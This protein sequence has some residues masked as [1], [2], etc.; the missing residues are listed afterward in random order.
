MEIWKL[1]PRLTER[2]WQDHAEAG[3]LGG[4]HDPDHAMRVSQV[5]FDLWP[6]VLAAAAG[7]CHNADR[8]LQHEMGVA[9]RN[10]LIGQIIGLGLGEEEREVLIDAVSKHVFVGR[11]DVP[12]ERVRELVMRE[13]SVEDCFSDRGIE[14]VVNAVLGHDGKNEEGD[15]IVLKALMD[16]DRLVNGEPDLV[17]R[18]GQFLSD[19][20]AV[21]PIY[22]DKDPSASYRDPRS[23]LRD[24]ME[25]IVW[26]T[27]G[28]N[29]P[30]YV[31][32]PKARAMAA[33]RKPFFDN[34]LAE[35]VRRREESG[36]HPYPPELIELR[37]RFMG[38]RVD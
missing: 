4:H 1:L 13:L 2:I 26:F 18:S 12:K 10:A 15:D 24:V 33:E 29:N 27:P 37:D 22:L 17:M 28:E 20:P 38:A 3:M 7:L 36:F 9:R 8:I 35:L 30:F 19:L 21:D 25:T 5:A 6:D 34:L 31:R 16:A 11:R 23:V 32:L 14:R